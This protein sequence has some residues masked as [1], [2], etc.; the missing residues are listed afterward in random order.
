[1]ENIKKV[2][3]E[4]Q[5]LAEKRTWLTKG[6]KD[7]IEKINTELSQIPDMTQGKISYLLREYNYSLN[8]YETYKR[9]IRVH[10]VFE[11]DAFLELELSKQGRDFWEKEVI[12]SPSIETIREFAKKLT[13]MFDFFLDEIKKINSENQI[14]I[15]TITDLI[16]KL[17]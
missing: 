8:S 12:K 16:S 5:K 10:L 7:L 3:E 9:K 14:V 2:V 1:M 6:Y 15:D 11:N 13:E 17:S 4:G